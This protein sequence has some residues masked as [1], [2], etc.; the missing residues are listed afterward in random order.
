MNNC[1][2][3]IDDEECKKRDDCLLNKNKKCQKKP[4]KKLQKD[5]QEGRRNK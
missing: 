2:D 1:K 4:T 3:I 5:K